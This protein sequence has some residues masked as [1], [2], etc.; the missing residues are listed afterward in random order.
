L[1]ALAY[2]GN[3][4]SEKLKSDGSAAPP[5]CMMDIGN[6]RPN[7]AKPDQD[8]GLA[9]AARQ[10]DRD[11]AGRGKIVGRA[12]RSD[13]DLIAGAGFAI[14]SAARRSA[15]AKLNICRGR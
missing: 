15:N 3:C 8:R 11:G 1:P 10:S 5:V 9:G 13:R 2:N 6:R 12:R 7:Y 14:A 4:L